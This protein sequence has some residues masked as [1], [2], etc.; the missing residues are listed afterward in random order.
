MRAT[1]PCLVLLAASLCAGGLLPAIGEGTLGLVEVL[2]AVK[3]EPD[4]VRQ[5][6]VELRRSDVKPAGIVS[7]ATLHGEEWRLLGAERTHFDVQVDR[8]GQLGRAP[9]NLLFQRAK[10]F[11]EGKFRRNWDP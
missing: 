5:I 2:E 6:D 3:G 9:D 8:L 4:L 10:Y 7:I 11:R 1:L